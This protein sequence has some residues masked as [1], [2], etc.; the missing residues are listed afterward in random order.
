MLLNINEERADQDIKDIIKYLNRCIFYQPRCVLELGSLPLMSLITCQNRWQLITS[1]INGLQYFK[2][3]RT[4]RW[5]NENWHMKYVAK[6]DGETGNRTICSQIGA[7]TGAEV[8]KNYMNSTLN[9]DYCDQIDILLVV[10][11]YGRSSVGL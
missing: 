11:L 8:G 3:T 7:R 9:I 2:P 6:P 5:S 4:I 10:L 1:Q